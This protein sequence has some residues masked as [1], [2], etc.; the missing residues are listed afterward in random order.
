MGKHDS[1]SH[2]LHTPK[3]EKFVQA[4]PAAILNQSVKAPHAPKP[5]HSSYNLFK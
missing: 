5:G 3:R 1:K 2:I 4:K